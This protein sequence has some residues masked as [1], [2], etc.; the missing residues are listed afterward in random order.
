MPKWTERRG[1]ILIH[2]NAGPYPRRYEVCCPN[3]RVNNTMVQYNNSE[4]LQMNTDN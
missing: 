2:R 3:C 1:K 4:S